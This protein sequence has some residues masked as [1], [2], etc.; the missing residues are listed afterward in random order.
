MGLLDDVAGALGGSAGG[1][2]G[3]GASLLGTYLTNDQSAS[4]AASAQAFSAQQY[5]S[6]YQTQVKDMEAAG[7]NPML[8]YMNAPPGSPQGVNAPVQNYASA[9]QAFNDTRSTDS[10][11]NLQ[12]SQADLN[13]AQS[14]LVDTTVAKVSAETR[15][16]DSLNDQIKAT[17]LNLA[18]T[19]DN[20]IKEGYNLTETGNVL[21]ASVEKIKS[22]VWNITSDTQRIDA[23][24]ALTQVQTQLGSFDVKAASDMGNLGRSAGQLKPI[25]DIIRGVL[26]RR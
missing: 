24:K 25:V 8:S 1:W 19:R 16:L 18:Q 2:L 4:N 15:N 14:Q 26:S 13:Q 11:I 12:S 9:V 5:A 6:R 20:M 7:L 10:N 17:V 23:V 22:E 3:A 21:R